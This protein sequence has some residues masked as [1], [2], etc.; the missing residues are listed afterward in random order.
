MSGAESGN[1]KYHL[2][3]FCV[4][5]P[6]YNE[7][8]GAEICIRRVCPALAAI[9]YPSKLITVNDGSRDQTGTILDRLAPEFPNLLVVHHAKNAGYGAALRTGVETAAEHGFD[10]ALFMDSD[11]TNDPADIPKF[12][13]VMERGIDVIKASRFISGGR[14]EGVPWQRSIFS[15]TGNLVARPLFHNGVR[16]CT[17]GFRAVKVDILKR[18]DLRERGFP[19]IVEE[20]YHAKFLARTYAEVPVVL[21]SRTGDQPPTSFAYTLSTIYKYFHYPLKA[22]LGIKPHLKQETR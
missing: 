6:M 14:M 16:D 8:R 18:M 9:P 11:L 10:Y 15:H 13:A 17:N 22:F 20:L 12:V 1:P 2:R 3:S 4:I 5:I 19:I 21:T 7:E